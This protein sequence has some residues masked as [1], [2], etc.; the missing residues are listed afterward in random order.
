MKKWRGGAPS[1]HDHHRQLARPD[2]QPMAAPPKGERENIE[3]KRK[4]GGGKGK[5]RKEEEKKKKRKGRKEEKK[6]KMDVLFC[7]SF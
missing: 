4:E 5:K 7:S 1:P 6:K 2:G 3:E